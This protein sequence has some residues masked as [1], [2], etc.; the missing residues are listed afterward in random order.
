MQQCQVRVFHNFLFQAFD[1]NKWCLKNGIHSG[2]LNPG[3]LTHESSALTTRPRLLAVVNEHCIA[4]CHRF[5]QVPNLPGLLFFT[6]DSF[7]NDNQ[8]F[9][10]VKRQI[11]DSVNYNSIFVSHG[12]L[13]QKISAYHLTYKVQLI[14]DWFK[15]SILAYLVEFKLYYSS[16]LLLWSRI[17]LFWIIFLVLASPRSCQIGKWPMDCWMEKEIW[18]MSSFA[19][20]DRMIM[21]WSKVITISSAYCKVSVKQKRDVIE[22]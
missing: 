21:V 7:D 9:L 1:P 5:F 19:Y 22:I 8:V 10:N 6:N 18:L 16:C 17:I 2:V 11:R 4:F 12:D 15:N 14:F 13:P 3:P 20:Y